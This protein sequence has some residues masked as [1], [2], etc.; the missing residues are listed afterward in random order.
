MA[1]RQRPS[2]PPMSCARKLERQLISLGASSQDAAAWAAT[3]S[4]VQAEEARQAQEAAAAQ[5][6]A[7]KEQAAAAG[8]RRSRREGCHASKLRSEAAQA[9]AGS[10]LGVITNLRACASSLTTTAAGLARPWIGSRRR[11]GNS[12][13]SSVRHRRAMPIPSRA[14][15]V[16]PRVFGRRHA[17]STAAV[18]AMSMRCAWSRSGSTRS[19]ARRGMRSLHELYGGECVATMDRIVDALAKLRERTPR[20]AGI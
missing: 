19:A 16:R 18:R 3:L 10:A 20:Y 11:S 13:R 7:A 6:A 1:A 8:C 2:P 12:M 4:Q 14:C 5:I 15:R 9:G 17:R